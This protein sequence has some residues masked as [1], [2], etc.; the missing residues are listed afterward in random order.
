MGQKSVTITSCPLTFDFYPESKI[1]CFPTTLTSDYMVAM[2]SNFLLCACSLSSELLQCTFCSL[3]SSQRRAGLNFI[4][5]SFCLLTSHF[6]PESTIKPCQTSLA[7]R[8]IYAIFSTFL[9]C[10]RMVTSEIPQKGFLVRI[11]K[12]TARWRNIS[13]H[14]CCV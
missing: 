4:T 8:Q 7:T 9:A 13:G 11:C 12:R 14:S 2:V 1:I 5:L 10:T 6:S 3:C